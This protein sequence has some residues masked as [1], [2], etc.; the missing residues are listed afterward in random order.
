LLVA[1]VLRLLG[2]G[3][4][5]GAGR[6]AAGRSLGDLLH[7]SQIDIQAR[8]LLPEGAA[9]DDFSPVFGDVGDAGQVIG[10]Q[11]ARTHGSI[12]LEVRAW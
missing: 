5:E 1:Q 3:F 8:S 4:F 12:F 6:Q 2:G 7:L 10:S 11:L 9:D